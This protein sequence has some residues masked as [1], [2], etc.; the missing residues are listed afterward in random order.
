MR[1]F[2]VT[3]SLT[4]RYKKRASNKNTKNYSSADLSQIL[5]FAP[6]TRGAQPKP[7]GVVAKRGQTPL[8]VRLG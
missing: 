8:K 6:A 3:H 4:F 5:G 2:D 7:I 1:L